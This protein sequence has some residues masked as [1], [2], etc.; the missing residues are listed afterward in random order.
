MKLLHLS[1]E[2]RMPGRL[3][4][5]FFHVPEINLEVSVPKEMVVQY[6]N[7]DIIYLTP[8]G[9]AYLDRELSTVLREEK[10]KI[11]DKDI[12]DGWE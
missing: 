5:Q 8:D 7:D 4:Y 9:L 12:E 3:S 1:V 11:S 10:P 2:L 6:P